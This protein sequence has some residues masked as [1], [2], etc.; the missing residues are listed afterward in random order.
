VNLINFTYG[1]SWICTFNYFYTRCPVENA[2][3]VVF[4]KVKQFHLIPLRRRFLWYFCIL[5]HINYKCCN[6]GCFS[7]MSSFYKVIIINWYFVATPPRPWPRPT[8]FKYKSGWIYKFNYIFNF[9]NSWICK[10]MLFLSYKLFTKS[11]LKQYFRT[12]FNVKKSSLHLYHGN[13]IPKGWAQVLI[14]SKQ[15]ERCGVR[16]TF[17]WDNFNNR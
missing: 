14:L 3:A 13:I 6:F 7:D 11:L 9:R 2:K 5:Q 15:E 8:I 4:L 17:N 10:V 12:L 1:N 16:I